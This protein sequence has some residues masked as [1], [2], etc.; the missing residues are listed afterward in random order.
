MPYGF[1]HGPY[2]DTINPDWLHVNTPDML[3]V[4]ECWRRHII[5]AH[6]VT[7]TRAE[8]KHLI[9]WLLQRHHAHQQLCADFRL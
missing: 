2:L 4:R 5:G 8:T 1:T 3:I 6:H 9:R 7:V